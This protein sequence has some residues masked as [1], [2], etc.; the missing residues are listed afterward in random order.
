LSQT[1]PARPI[2]VTGSNR[3]GTTWV[4]RMLCAS[5]ELNYVYEPFNPGLW[6]RWTAEPIPY[7]NFYICAENEDAW[8]GPIG[9]VIACRRP[10]LAQLREA[11]SVKRLAKLARDGALS[12]LMRARQRRTLVKDPIAVFSAP[13]LAERF[14][15][16][17]V[18]MIRNPAAFAGSIKR[19]GWAF[20]FRNWL[21]QDLLMRDHLWPFERDIVRMTERRADLIDQAILLWNVHHHVIAT[22]RD[23]YPQWMFLIHESLSQDPITGFRSLYG[24]LGLPFDR[25]AARVISAH[26]KPGNP[27]E[28]PPGE[29]RTLRRDSRLATRTWA[30]RLS[31]GEIARVREG[32]A[33]VAE[34]FYPGESWLEGPTPGTAS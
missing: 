6:P 24:R 33:A 10:V 11:R 22:F 27:A 30:S 34:R 4:G 18:V 14:D 7:R 9:D 1:V 29:T 13:W 25:T 15:A 26:S 5:R 16:D 19:L 21:H 31:P 32:V 8:L 28:V 20:D 12:A 23:R 2:L 17:V 3:S